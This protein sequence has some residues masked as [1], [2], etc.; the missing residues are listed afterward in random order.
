MPVAPG[1]QLNLRRAVIFAVA[2]LA[3]GVALIVAVIALSG[4]GDLEVNLGSNVFEVGDAEEFAAKIAQDRAPR[5]F[6]SL[7]DNRPIYLQHLG[8]D[9]STGWYAIDARSPS[10]PQDCA[11]EW[12]VDE[13]HFVDACDPGTVFPADGE[14]LLRYRVIVD[15]SGVV[16]VDLRGEATTPTPAG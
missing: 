8:E 15:T 7:E 6:S 4:S 1:P 9:S 2:S 16:R 12:L 5:V 11:L 10:S 3:L 14:G 13:Q